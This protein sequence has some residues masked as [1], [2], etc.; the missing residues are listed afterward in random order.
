MRGDRLISILLLLQSHG[1]MTAGELAEQLEV[2][3]RTIYRD[4]EALSGTGIPVVAERGKNGGWSLLENYTTDL[5]GLKEAEIQALFVS[6]PAYLLEDLGLTRISQEAR[7]KLIASLPTTYRE[8]A[9]DV[10]NRIHIDTRSWRRQQGK[11]ASFDILKQAIW[12]ENKLKITYQQANGKTDDRTV[13]PLG[14]VAKGDLWYLIAA[15]DNGDLRNY[16]ASRIQHAELLE[17]TFVR[18][19]DFDLAEYWNSSTKAFIK[20]LPSYEVKVE[21]AA[22]VV[23]RLTFSGRFAR[24]LDVGSENTDGRVLVTL[25]FD[26]EEEAAGYLLG[27]GDQLKVVEPEGLSRRIL[28]MAVRT[29]A[30]Y[31]ED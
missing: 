10:W 14:L 7:N 12:E 23:S 26:T 19:D 25:S 21:A 3:E 22:A 1:R 13:S 20:N 2:S 16:R 6:P 17:E 27:F 30:F 11:T 9:K 4:M 8:N 31:R 24:V 5:T 29:V 15:K 28:E 18:P